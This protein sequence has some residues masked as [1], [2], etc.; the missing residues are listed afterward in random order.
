MRTLIRDTR[1][2]AVILRA[3]FL[4]IWLTVLAEL[5]VT[6][7]Y[8]S[9][10][11]LCAVLGVFCLYDN[12]KT[13]RCCEGKQKWALRIF[14]AVFS[15]SV[16]FANYELFEPLSVLQ[17]VFEAGCC[18]AGGYFL[19][20]AVLVYFLDRL[21]FVTGI[22]GRKYPKAVFLAVFGT[23]AF[24][25]LLY[26]FFD[27]YPGILTV[28]SVSTIKQVMHDSSYNNTMPFW[29]TMTV[30]LFVRPVLALT[31]DICAAV[32]CFH[33]AQ[34]LFMAACFAYVMMTLHQMDVPV[35]CLA[36][37]YA[38]YAFQPHNIVYSVTLWKDIPFAGAAVL[39]ITALYRL[40][41][42]IGKS[43]FLNY[44]VFVIG[45]LGFSLWRT[46][47]WYAFLVTVLLMVILMGKRQKKLILLMTI[48]LVVSWLLIN[49]VLTLLGVKATNMVEAFA[50]PM[51][52][53][54]RVV[55]EGRELTDRENE[56]LSE[57]FWMDK[58]P[59]YY[60][61]LTVDPIKFET[62]RYD[63]VPHI[64]EHKGDYLKLYVS[65]GL[66]YPGDY[67]KAWIDETKGYWNGGYFFWIYTKQMDANPYGIV[68]TVEGNLI[69]KLFAAV[70]RYLEKPAFL[71][72][73]VSIGL[74]VWA[75][76]TCTLVNALKKREEFLLGIPL[77]V[78]V[79]GLWLGTPVY[80]EFRYAYPIILS[81]PM[82]LAA[83]VFGKKN[84]K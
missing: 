54:A 35:W 51:Q 21:P 15:A 56:L 34:I 49:P 67:L 76:V 25:D 42:G 11:L 44:L 48:V 71:Q 70:F 31:G 45:A 24:I 2:G 23:I 10:Y 83:T 39:F 41:K 81:M 9:V 18:L 36:G 68:N 47:G 72:P 40:L 57:I 38:V 33:V 3:F 59:D 43:R 28:D 75:L 79:A 20:E 55:S 14:S 13:G 37:V 66:K 50:V 82:I 8:Y 19:G 5:S 17:N 64:L 61:P 16:V 26:L 84:A 77:L 29:H 30:Q 4:Y 63:Q 58:V 12:Y 65:L 80:S 60:D 52:Q 69:Q 53:V 1:K 27:A 22:D 46:N 7:T 62:F 32:A 6:D 73:L 74:H 78:L